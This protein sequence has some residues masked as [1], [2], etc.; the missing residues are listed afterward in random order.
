MATLDLVKCCKIFREMGRWR[1]GL[2]DAH[3]NVR[4]SLRKEGRERRQHSRMLITRAYVSVQIQRGQHY[5][6]ACSSSQGRQHRFHL[7]RTCRSIPRQQHYSLSSCVPPHIVYPSH[8]HSPAFSHSSFLLSSRPSQKNV[9]SVP[10]PP[11]I[12]TPS[13]RIKVDAERN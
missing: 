1:E 4:I 6:Q 7:W 9:E 5:S 13:H 8:P 10:L 11:R 3:I 2:S 12:H